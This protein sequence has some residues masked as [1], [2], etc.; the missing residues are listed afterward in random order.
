[1]NILAKYIQHNFHINKSFA[2]FVQILQLII[3]HQY[4]RNFIMIYSCLLRKPAVAR[5]IFFNKGILSYTLKHR[6]TDLISR[7]KMCNIYSNITTI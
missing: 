7:L 3:Q 6:S 2:N 5:L 1:M 4:F